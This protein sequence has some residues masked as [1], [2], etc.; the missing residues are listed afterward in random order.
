MGANLEGGGIDP[1]IMANH[2][3]H[4]L[5][6]IRTSTVQRGGT[7]A[8]EESVDGLNIVEKYVLRKHPLT[9]MGLRTSALSPHQ[10]LQSTIVS[11]KKRIG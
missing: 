5:S 2:S 6:Q 4:V 3:E 7:S 1:A 8:L 9:I 10:S 11:V